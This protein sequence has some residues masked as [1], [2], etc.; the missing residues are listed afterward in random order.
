MINLV[1][2]LIS[3]I[4]LRPIISLGSLFLVA[5]VEKHS[6]REIPWLIISLFSINPDRFQFLQW[7]QR[8]LLIRCYF[9]NAITIVQLKYQNKNDLRGFPS[10]AASMKKNTN[11]F[12]RLFPS[13]AGKEMQRRLQMA[14]K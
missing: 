11:I 6:N 10:L 7:N 14:L 3:V 13:L 4:A 5:S 1:G 2:Q 8:M 12:S 9:Y